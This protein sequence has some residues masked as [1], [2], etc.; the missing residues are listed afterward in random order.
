MYCALEA[1]KELS[2]G[3]RCVVLLPD[4]IRNYL[5]KFADDRWMID[6]EFIEPPPRP[7]VR[8]ETVA[9]IAVPESVTVPPSTTVKQAIDRIAAT[10]RHAIAIVNDEGVVTGVLTNSSLIDAL[11]TL[12]PNGSVRD[13]ALATFRV[14]TED[15]PVS[16]LQYALDKNDGVVTVI[17]KRDNKKYFIKLIVH[18]DLLAHLMHKRA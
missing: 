11:Y 15:Y 6:Y 13:A 9:A 10:G 5:G 8:D 2:A 4:G 17:E 3:Q 14:V 1:A 18:S 12:G 16:R 7:L